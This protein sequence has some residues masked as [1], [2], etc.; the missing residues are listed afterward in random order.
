MEALINSCIERIHSPGQKSPTP[1]G[2]DWNANMA[3]ISLFW[4]TNMATGPLF[5]ILAQRMGI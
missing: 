2:F 4:N 1:K 5:Q 3:A